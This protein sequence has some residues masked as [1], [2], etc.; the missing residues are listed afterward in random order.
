M[1]HRTTHTNL[2]KLF[3]QPF[4]RIRSGLLGLTQR[5]FV[6]SD[7]AARIIVKHDAEPPSSSPQRGLA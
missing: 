5:L 3:N 4:T 1:P 6:A 2:N 7:T